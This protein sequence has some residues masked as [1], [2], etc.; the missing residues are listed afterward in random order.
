M[1]T[2][3][4]YIYYLNMKH[5]PSGA[6][7]REDYTHMSFSDEVTKERSLYRRG[8][9]KASRPKAV[10]KKV[11][12][13]QKKRLKQKQK[14]I[15]GAAAFDKHVSGGPKIDAGRQTLDVVTGSSK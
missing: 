6:D 3:T 10:P 4:E 12:A 1:G 5:P 9:K 14:Y 8:L 7:R 11:T 13:A 15:A 2:A